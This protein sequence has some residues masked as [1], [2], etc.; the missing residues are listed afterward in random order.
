M[1]SC[2]R[3]TTIP[4][5][6]S[7]PLITLN[8]SI[9][10]NAPA[11]ITNTASVSGGGET[12]TNNNS[13]SNTVSVTVVAPDLTITK[14]TSSAFQRGGTAIYTLTVNNIGNG[15][16]SAGYTISDNLPAGLTT[17]AIAV[18]G[19]WDCGPSTGTVLSCSRNTAIPSGASAPV[20]TLTVNIAANAPASITNTATV[21]GGGELVTNNNNS[22]V[23]STVTS[24]PPALVS[25][26][27]QQVQNGIFYNLPI[28]Y[29]QSIKGAITVEPRSSANG[30]NLIF[31]F[32]S[33][34]TS[35]DPVAVVVDA[36]D[37]K[38]TDAAATASGAVVVVNLGKI[39]DRQRITVT[40]TGINGFATVALSM[41]FMLGDFNSSRSVDAN[42]ITA[43][44]AR[45]GESNS[46]SNFMFDV[47][48]TGIISAADI[49]AVKARSGTTLP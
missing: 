32:A 40:L 42:D 3:S 11:S 7:A 8:V 30:F 20:V 39:P 25:V 31:Q 12:V 22:S 33:P 24:P 43:I 26:V 47:N 17:T 1:A 41:G 38:L 23:T 45:A 18:S 10:A 37:A 14:A 9:A 36:N 49:A 4:A 2:T 44:K 15:A 35:V 13:A 6:V 21:S 46:L 27:S 34:I 29:L 5:G 19:G 16:T 48:R 28:D